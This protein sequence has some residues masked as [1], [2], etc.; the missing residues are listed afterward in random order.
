LGGFAKLVMIVLNGAIFLEAVTELSTPRSL[1][2]KLFI[3]TSLTVPFHSF[4]ATISSTLPA[5]AAHQHQ[6][7]S[8][9]MKLLVVLSNIWFRYQT[10]KRSSSFYL[11][12]IPIYTN[13]SLVFLFQSPMR[14]SLSI[15]ECWRQELSHH[16]RQII[17]DSLA[18]VKAATSRLAPCQS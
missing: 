1:S 11:L 17:L 15:G 18:V 16:V 6:Y 8:S 2:S 14:S 9:S 12:A 10:E 4:H 3:Q 7:I 5:L 13:R